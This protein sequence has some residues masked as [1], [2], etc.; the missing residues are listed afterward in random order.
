MGWRYFVKVVQLLSLM[1]SGIE[2]GIILMWMWSMTKR[3]HI[4]KCVHYRIWR[5]WV[6]G[7]VENASVRMVM[8]P[9]ISALVPHV[10]LAPLPC[11]NRDSA[12]PNAT[13]V[14]YVCICEHIC[15]LKI[16]TTYILKV[17]RILVLDLF[18]SEVHETFSP[19]I[20]IIKICS[21]SFPNCS[22]STLSCHFWHHVLMVSWDQIFHH[23]HPNLVTGPFLLTSQLSSIVQ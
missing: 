14:R 9:V 5:V 10:Q 17:P 11:L 13:Q 20:Q 16:Y 21:W 2:D 15:S 8:W 12:A 18:S 22:F 7:R 6:M 1:M 19:R 3:I 4:F 23:L